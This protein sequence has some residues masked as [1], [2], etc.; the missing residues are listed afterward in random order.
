MPKYLVQASYTAEGIKGLQKEGATGRV[1]AVKRAV[2]GLGG[3]VEVF[4]WAF[5]EHDV[6]AIFDVPDNTKAAALSLSVAASGLV[7]IAT[8]PLMPSAEVD[9]ALKETVAY[10][11]PGR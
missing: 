10:R 4:Y 3:K 5:G 1:E 7:R 6:I 8:I 2:E 9:R 11:P